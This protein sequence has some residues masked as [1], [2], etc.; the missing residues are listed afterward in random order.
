VNSF[1]INNKLSLDF[2]VY[3]YIDIEKRLAISEDK[4]TKDKKKSK[5]I[6][7]FL[8]EQDKII[9]NTQTIDKL[10]DEPKDDNFEN[11]TSKD[12]WKEFSFMF[13]FAQ[14]LSEILLH[15][16]SCLVEDNFS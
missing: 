8:Y 5:I 1:G 15:L 10:I 14:K 16:T 7:N 11:C 4:R 12:I 2:I 6:T 9:D 13:D 3:K